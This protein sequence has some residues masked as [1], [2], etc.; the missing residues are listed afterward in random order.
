MHPDIGMRAAELGEAEFMYAMFACAD[1]DSRAALGMAQHRVGGGEVTVMANDPTGSY[2][3]RAIGLGVRE[4]LTP[5]VV[6]EVLDFTREHGGR[7]MVFQLAPGASPRD[8]P[9]L[10]SDYGA[11]P[12]GTWVKFAGD[13]GPRP[14]VPTDLKIDVLGREHAREFARVMCTGFRMPLDSPLPRWFGGLPGWTAAGFTAY[15][16]W[17]GQDLV[18]TGSL[19]V[20]EGVATLAGAATLPS[21]RGRGAQTA[22][23]V[24]RIRDAA[25]AGCGVVTCETGSEAR[26]S[27]N[28]SLHNMRRLGLTELYERRNWLWRDQPEGA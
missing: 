25:A 21:H 12:G 3:S 17:D 5:A 11:V 26:D 22:L 28:P 7:T 4:P 2:W 14:E 24:R 13:T 10:L 1:S 9:D 18:A 15:G 20:H 6:D 16:A 8:W 19:F 23:M 27:P